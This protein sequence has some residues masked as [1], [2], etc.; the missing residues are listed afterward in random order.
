MTELLLIGAGG[1]AREVLACV[2]D[3]GQFDV[4]GV[5]DD[6]D[7]GGVTTSTARPI[8]GPASPPAGTRKRGLVVCIGPGHGA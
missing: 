1:L 6:I 3:N 4:V 2:R 5:L 7:Q 8:L